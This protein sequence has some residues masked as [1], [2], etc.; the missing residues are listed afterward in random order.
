MNRALVLGSTSP[1]R[2]QLL[3]KLHIPFTCAA[4]AIDETRHQGE[5]A[6]E[7]VQRLSL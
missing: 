1:F 6:A 5:S 3:E 4:P 2:R 7:M